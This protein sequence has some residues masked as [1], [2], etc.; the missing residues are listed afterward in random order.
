MREQVLG[1]QH[2]D[3]LSSLHN[4]LSFLLDHK[5]VAWPGVNYNFYDLSKHLVTS[6]MR[7]LGSYHPDTLLSYQKLGAFFQLSI[8]TSQFQEVLGEDHPAVYSHKRELAKKITKKYGY[9]N[10]EELF[11]EALDNLKRLLGED[12]PETLATMHA[13][14]EAMLERG[15]Y[16]QSEEMFRDVLR[17]REEILRPDHPDTLLTKSKLGQLLYYKGEDEEAEK[18][19][20][21][22][23]AKFEGFIG[24]KHRE[25]VMTAMVLGLLI[26]ERFDCDAA[27]V[28]LKWL[29][30]YL[31]R[32]KLFTERTPEVATVRHRIGTILIRSS[33]YSDALYQISMA[34]ED[35]IWYSTLYRAD[36]FHP[37]LDPLLE[38]MIYLLRKSGKTEEEVDTYIHEFIECARNRSHRWIFINCTPERTRDYWSEV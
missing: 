2:P 14:A 21:E 28:F 25:T 20:A 6:R 22:A 24:P 29:I 3:T 13:F 26:S 35:L 11:Q 1:S 38:K 30:R 5:N 32:S 4:Y 27:E 34:T 36:G 9:E 19:L 23:L 17:K 33:R 7:I 37:E 18:L 8:D 16:D 31:L 15:H 12:H 10:A